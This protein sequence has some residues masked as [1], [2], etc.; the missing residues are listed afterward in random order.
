[1]GTTV[2]CAVCCN[3]TSGPLSRVCEVI[4]HGDQTFTLHQQKYKMSEALKT[5]EATLLFGT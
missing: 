2:T 5:G 3:D 4:L 1:M